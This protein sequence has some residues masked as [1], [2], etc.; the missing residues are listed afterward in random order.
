MRPHPQPSRRRGGLL[1]LLA[2][3]AF[4]VSACGGSGASPNPSCPADVRAPGTSPALEGLLP[5]SLDDAAP[6]TVDSGRNCTPRA[7]GTLAARGATGVRFAGAT[8]DHG[9]SDGT[10]IAVFAPPA[11]GGTLEA[12]WMEEFYLEGARA[13]TKTENIST[14]RPQT[15]AAG[16]V[17]RL[18]TLNDLS[19]QTV[20]VWPGDEVVHVVIVAT[21]VEPNASRAEHDRRVD[22]AIEAAVSAAGAQG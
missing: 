10:V 6:T 20:V 4:A 7:V 2:A 5:M 3:V 15:G 21:R 16:T 22:R 14:S 13:S 18:E 19:L 8:W 9:D 11:D 12:A 17:F 1:A